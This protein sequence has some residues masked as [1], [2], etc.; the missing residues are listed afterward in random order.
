[1]CV[2]VVQG[3]QT[4][5]AS[6]LRGGRNA[7]PRDR[8]GQDQRRHIVT[9]RSHVTKM[10]LRDFIEGTTAPRARI[11]S[12]I[13][14][15]R[16]N[17][18]LVLRAAAELDSP[19][20]GNIMAGRVLLFID[21]KVID[22][23][24][25]RV[26]VGVDSSPRGVAIKPLGWVTAIKDG[27]NKLTPINAPGSSGT[28]TTHSTGSEPPPPGSNDEGPNSLASRIAK[29]RQSRRDSRVVTPHSQTSVS[30]AT[31]NQI[32]QSG[33]AQCVD[34][35]KATQSEDKTTKKKPAL[36]SV[37][38]LEE[39]EQEQLEHIQQLEAEDHNT[40]EA[41]LGRLLMEQNLRV[42]ELVRQWD[43]NQDGDISK[44]E[45]RINVRKLGLTEKMATSIQLDQLYNSLDLDGSGQLETS[46]V[47]VALKRL[48]GEAS[49]VAGEKARRLAHCA[50]L[51]QVA[52]LY[53]DARQAAIELREAELV[54]REKKQPLGDSVDV[55]LGAL[56]KQQ[57]IRIL[58]M[59]TKWDTGTG[60][61]GKDAFREN[62]KASLPT[63][64]GSAAELS[65]LFKQ[66]D[67][68]GSGVLSLNELKGHLKAMQDLEARH[69]QAI[70]EQTEVVATK[71]SAAR[72]TQEASKVALDAAHAERANAE[73]DALKRGLRSTDSI[74]RGN[75][76]AADVAGGIQ[77]SSAGGALESKN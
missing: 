11:S 41:K 38:Q 28:G 8:Y 26:R 29:R 47:R 32:E 75:L 68:E 77:A 4:K 73:A 63:F 25:V 56:L 19:K 40:L 20:K 48:Q 46:E 60:T 55:R 27:D 53:R 49:N 39:H 7:L 5:K 67:T 2:G 3:R 62:L 42:D 9:R 24:D 74:R 15:A 18:K 21:E 6:S 66:L 13:W 10:L 30:S 69:V 61:I 72:A 59:V 70:K 35:S 51:K 1:M 22:T 14:R 50:N 64:K 31:A 37:S 44:Q 16:A 65:D 12:R 76:P 33:E 58:E 57:Q 45:F 71:R 17:T 54:H 52:T 43:R 36:L 34:G 23:G